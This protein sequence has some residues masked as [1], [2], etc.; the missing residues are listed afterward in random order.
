ML[1]EVLAKIGINLRPFVVLREGIFDHTDTPRIPDPDFEAVEIKYLEAADM[2]V[3]A[4]LSDLPGRSITEGELQ[5][6]LRAG[7]K[8]AAL[9]LDGELAAFTWCDFETCSFQGYPFSLKA[10]EVYLFDAYTLVAFRGKGL[11]P[12]IRYSLYVDLARQGREFCYSVSDRF[13]RPSLRFKEKLNA[14]WLISGVYLVL[15]S[16]WRFTFMLKQHQSDVPLRDEPH[17]Y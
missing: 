14:R 7:N 8:C 11:A 12:Y 17:R 6:R 9:T 4:S 5:K 1:L 10:N 15:F 2:R 3:L 13:N 16:R